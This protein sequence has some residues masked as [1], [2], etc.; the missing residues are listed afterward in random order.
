MARGE[1][2]LDF[3]S[4][5]WITEVERCGEDDYS[6]TG[7][8][9]VDSR[10]SGAYTDGRAAFDAFPGADGLFFGEEVRELPDG[11]GFYT[12]D[13]ALFVP[14]PGTMITIEVDPEA[15]PGGAEDVLSVVEGI[16]RA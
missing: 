10:R 2:E 11:T 13:A 8:I 4:R 1:G 14:E 6:W 3:H 9:S 12:G 5:Q 15:A 7:G 16:E